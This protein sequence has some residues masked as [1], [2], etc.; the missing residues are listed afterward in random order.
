MEFLNIFT[1]KDVFIAGTG[2][3]LV[4]MLRI[5]YD[6]YVERKKM[7]NFSQS[8]TIYNSLVEES[9]DGLLIISEDNN[10]IFAN[11]EVANILNTPVGNFDSKDLYAIDIANEENGTT[12]SLLETIQSESYMENAYLV[13]GLNSLPISMSVN[14]VSVS[15]DAQNYWYIGILR[16]MT[17]INDLRE[18]TRELLA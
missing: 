4:S 10:V 2:L 1:L 17:N 9:R 14:K 13:N 7:K 15:S 3:V 18:G 6:S 16:D 8:L 5:Y 12:R 11:D